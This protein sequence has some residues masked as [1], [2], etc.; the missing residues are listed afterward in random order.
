MHRTT[1]LGLALLCMIFVSACALPRGAAINTEVLREQNKEEPTFS[2]MPVT[3]ANLA[4]IQ[5]WPVTGWGGSYHWLGN[6]RGPASNVIRAGDKV[7]LVIW[8]S[9]ENSLLTGEAERAV[10]M[11]GITV[12]PSGTIFVPYLDEIVVNGLTESQARSRIQT[13]LEPIIAS[14][15]VQVIHQPGKNNSVDLVSGVTKPGAYPLPDR[16]TT[17]LSLIAQG[18]GISTALRNPLVRLIRGSK[19]YEIRSER[20]FADASKNVTL[21]GNDKLLVQEDDRYFS[22]L[23]AAGEEQLVYFEKE[24]ITAIEAVSMMGG[25]ADTRANPKGVLVLREYA[26]RQMRS[27]GKGPDMPYVVFTFDLTSADGLFAARKFQVNPKDTVLATE[28]PVNAARTIF[29]LIGSTVG[30]SNQ[31]AN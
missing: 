18:G 20:L 27:D 14:A 21:R 5:S 13:A 10:A 24:D 25:L 2:V 3:R 19:T 16:N 31:L 23:G 8:D 9:T 28:S 11:Q 6:S 22:A 30:L 12:S 1:R 17:V 26:P 29:G 7:D 15:Q 4:E